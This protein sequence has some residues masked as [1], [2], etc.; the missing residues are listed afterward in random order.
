[1]SKK[2]KTEVAKVETV[3]VEAAEETRG[4][5]PRFVGRQY[6]SVVALL[7]LHGPTMTRNILAAPAMTGVGRNRKPN[8]LAAQRP[9]SVFP[10]PESVSLPTLVKIGAEA[11]IEF[12]QGKENPIASKGSAA[13][14]HA[15]AL[16]AKHGASKAAEVLTEEGTAVCAATLRTMAKAAGM[17]LVRG[18][19]AS[20]AAA[21]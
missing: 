21:A 2:S 12:T 3:V 1:M 14:K 17:T 18:R 20:E 7:K 13:V 11:G 5:P 8:P 4:R 9:A 15:L 6:K 19:R 10:E 16:V